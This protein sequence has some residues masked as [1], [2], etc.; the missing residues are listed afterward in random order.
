MPKHL[1]KFVFALLSAALTAC[2]QATDM[3]AAGSGSALAERPDSWFLHQVGGKHIA[4][5]GQVLD[6][7][8]QY[9][10]QQAMTAESGE[11]EPDAGTA[12]GRASLRQVFERQWE[13]QT[14]VPPDMA[15][16]R[17]ISIPSRD[18]ETIPAR[19]YRPKGD[20]ALPVLVYFHGGGWVFG[21]VAAVDRAARLLADEARVVVV[22]VDYRLAPE[23]PYPAA[24]NDAEDAFAWALAQA[25]QFGGD[26]SRVCVGGDSAGGNLSIAVSSRR[27]R[28]GQT[29]PNCQL[30]YYPGVDNRDI[31]T[32]RANYLSSR[33]FGV[34]F[35]LDYTFTE[36]VLPL[37]FPGRDL[38]SPEISPL[39][40]A[41]A[42]MAQ[43][44]PTV[45][46]ASGFDP[47]RDSNRAY[48]AKLE[49]AGVEVRYR[50]FPSL[51]HGIINLTAVT[52]AAHR[53]AL[54]T[55]RDLGRVAHRHN[56]SGRLS[57][58]TSGR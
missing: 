18:G 19:A 57:G 13:A 50:E 6:V 26:T 4:V 34:G 56:M 31:P 11:N 29:P 54:L 36:F 48:A 58:D 21:S 20:G 32:M 52:P 47:L 42:E 45:L 28:A 8:V 40:A 5:D 35:W 53:A 7:R 27:L 33:L 43:L 51:I 39:F 12:E 15:W 10:M 2:T 25:E 24:W 16:V 30:L 3:D 44:P 38:A 46:V 41:R 14:R 55:A 1:S 37:T 49:E 23:A 22:S 17:D 9:L